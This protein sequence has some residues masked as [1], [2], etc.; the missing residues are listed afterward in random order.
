[1]LSFLPDRLT[2]FVNFLLPP[3]EKCLIFFLLP[4]DKNSLLFSWSMIF[5]FFPQPIDNFCDFFPLFTT[6]FCDF[7]LRSISNSTKGEFSNLFLFGADWQRLQVFYRERLPKVTCFLWS[8]TEYTIFSQST[9]E[10]GD[11]FPDWLTNFTSF[12]TN[13]WR[14]SQHF[15]AT[16]W[17]I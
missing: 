5:A 9:E 3:T 7:L 6:E 11:I 14:T 1:M 2:D 10:F 4:I 15:K 17:K 8:I 12:P 16:N 13:N